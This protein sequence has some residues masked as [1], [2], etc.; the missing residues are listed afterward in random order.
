MFLDVCT[1]ALSTVTLIISSRPP[2]PRLCTVLC[3]PS[4]HTAQQS[5]QKGGPELMSEC[6]LRQLRQNRGM[7]DGCG[8]GK[9]DVFAEINGPRPT[10]GHPRTGQVGYLLDDGTVD[11]D[12]PGPRIF[13]PQHFRIMDLHES[14][15]DATWI[16]NWRDPG[17]WVD[18]L[19]KWDNV[20]HAQFL[21]EYY[22]QGAIPHIPTDAEDKRELLIRL[23]VEHHEMVRDFV[24]RHPSHALV[25]VNITAPNAGAALADAFGLRK[26]AWTNVNRNKLADVEW[27]ARKIST[28][29]LWDSGESTTPPGPIWWLLLLLVG[30]T[31]YSGWRWSRQRRRRR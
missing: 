16:L 10:R 15:P 9:L 1:L 21:N 25:E 4:P 12:G 30:S 20:T 31:T 18:S 7:L 23:Y 19:M 24:R 8:A 22:M 2:F 17:E 28:I 6:L 5:A 27:T 11:Y 14:S 3:A 13:L 29:T 26:D